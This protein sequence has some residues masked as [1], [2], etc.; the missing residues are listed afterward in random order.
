MKSIDELV[1]EKLIDLVHLLLAKLI[2]PDF[3]F[4]SVTD[5]DET[6]VDEIKRK[7]GIE[8][9]IIDVDDTLRKGFN[10]IPK[11][12]KEWIESLK[13]KL[14]ITI[15]S[16]G[17]DQVIEDYFKEQGIDYIGFGMKPRKKNFIKACQRMKVK[18]EQVMV[19]GDELF[20]DVWRRQKKQNE[21]RINKM[22]LLGTL[23]KSTILS[24]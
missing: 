19:V 2:K 3:T 8:G 10:D 22:I 16:N 1:A 24:F 12:H 5:I 7:Y 17:M 18:P 14:K 6:M 21:N 11:S 20:Q 15:L 9:I 13:G 23:Q 4:R